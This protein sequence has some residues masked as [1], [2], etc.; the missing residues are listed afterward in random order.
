[1]K[2]K[3]FLSALVMG[4]FLTVKAQSSCATALNLPVGTTTVTEITGSYE[5]N[6]WESSSADAANWYSYT[7]AENGAVRI[8]TNLAVNDGETYSDDTRVSVYSGSC[9]VLTCWSSADDFDLAS[10]NYL[11]DFEF[12]VLSGQ[13]YYIA[14]DNNWSDLGFQ[15]EVSFTALSCFPVT[16]G[17]A[18][19]GTPTSSQVTIEWN[20]ALNSPIGYEVLWGEDGFDPETEGTLIG[21]LT[22]PQVTI[23]GLTGETDYAFYVRTICSGEDVSEWVGPITFTTPVEPAN[24]PYSFG[25]EEEDGTGWTLLNAGAGSDWNVEMSSDDIQAY[26][27]DVFAYAGAFP[28]E[29]NAWLF[30]RAVNLT[31]G[32]SYSVS[33]YLRKYALEGDGNVN[34]FEV[35][36]GTEPTVAAQTTVLGTFDDFSEEEYV[37]QTHTFTVPETGVYYIGFN[38]TAPAHIETNYGVL[39][40]D[41]FSVTTVLGINEQVAAKLSVYPNPSKNVVNVSNSDNIL[42]NAVTVTDINGRTVKSA[43]YDN[44]S[45]LEI[46]IGDLASGMYMMAIASDNG[47]AIKKI[48]KN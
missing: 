45:N 42:I 29:S 40:F 36:L 46:N 1:M 4:S 16:S 20:E 9:A 38:Y 13:T 2:K 15:V 5:D 17:L 43:K 48:V 8:N 32:T 44:V 21:G 11:T 33:Y 28:E 41:N 14:F 34:N 30:S 37:Q 26:Q 19:V 22:T 3:L 24:V 10:Q 39:A 25:F 31:E 6:C 23:M 47:I 18:F 7:A 27:G 12:Q 35:T